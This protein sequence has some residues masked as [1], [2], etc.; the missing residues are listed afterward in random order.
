M[1]L[2][3]HEKLLVSS[4]LNR[5]GK[6]M[7]LAY[8]LLIFLGTLGIHRFYLDKKGTAITQLILSVVGGLTAII[9]IG[10]I[11]LIIVG[12]WLFIDLF[13]VPGMVE[14]ENERIEQEIIRNLR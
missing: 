11:P 9:L 8:V 2:T 10:F 5:K 14:K 1:A 4:E 3:D 6:N 13:L 7:L 12:I